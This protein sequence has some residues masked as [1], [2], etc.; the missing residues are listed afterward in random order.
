[1]LPW[2]VAEVAA[3]ASSGLAFLLAVGNDGARQLAFAAAHGGVEAIHVT[4]REAAADALA[5]RLT[6][7]DVVLLKASDS[8]GLMTLADEL[9][10]APGLLSGDG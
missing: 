8:V 4:D 6:A 5:G 2:T 9:A 1:M 3:A 10:A 7:G